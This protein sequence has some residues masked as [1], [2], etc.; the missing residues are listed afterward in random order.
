MIT[1]FEDLA[2]AIKCHFNPY[3]ITLFE[4]KMELEPECDEASKSKLWD[5]NF[6]ELAEPLH[7]VLEY[8][9]KA[10]RKLFHYLSVGFW[11]D[12]LLAFL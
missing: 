3:N 1:R 12:T 11:K 6:M 10:S 5:T 7:L 2:A 4:A 9:N 8:F